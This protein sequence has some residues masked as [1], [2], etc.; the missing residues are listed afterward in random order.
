MKNIILVTLTIFAFSLT[1]TAQ[2][3]NGAIQKQIKSLKADKQI[4]LTYD[5]ASNSSKIFV[6]ADNFSDAESKKAGI[7]AMNFGMAINYAGNAL[8]ATPENIDLAFWV[9]SKKPVFTTSRNW[10]VTLG[11]D[12]LN[13]GDARYSAKPGENME[14]LNFKITREE[15]VKIATGTNVKFHLGNTEFTFTPEHLTMFKNLLT[16]SDFH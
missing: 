11:T 7:Q 3:T 9:M 5:N 4:S 14:Y 13:F 2:K 10:T 6:R 8:A 16:I 1:T 15:L 12:T